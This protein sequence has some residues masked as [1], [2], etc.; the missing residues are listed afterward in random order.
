MNVYDEITLFYKSYRGEKR[1][2]GKSAEGRNL[3]AMF[4]G[5]HETPVGISQAAIHGREFVTAELSL[6]HIRRGVKKGGVW[7]L[8]LTNPD[9]ALLSQIGLTTAS[10]R[11][12]KF[13]LGLNGGHDFS[14]WKANADG[15]DLN[16]NFDARWGT[17]A[18]NIRTPAPENFIGEAPLCAPESSALAAFTGEVMPDFTVSWHTK[19]EEIYWRFHQSFF[20]A[21]RDKRIAKILSKTTGYPLKEAKRSAGGYKDW[22]VESLKIPAFTVE[23][24]GDALSH[25]L[26]GEALVEIIEKNGDALR[27]LTEG[28]KWKRNTCAR[29]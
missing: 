5:R 23:V 22:C 6:E 15:V 27:A 29:R 26:G 16:V 17:G 28:Y 8:P 10:E 3:Y 19:G 14:L 2:Y 18:R 9:G 24:G 25:P 13:L 12:R 1:V 4:I 11:R 7:V 20:R 21:V